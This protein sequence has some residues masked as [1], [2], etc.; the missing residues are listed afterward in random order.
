MTSPEKG[1]VGVG[2]EV[3]EVSSCFCSFL[4]L[5]QVQVFNAPRCRTLEEYGISPPILPFP[6]V[7]KVSLRP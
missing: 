3:S 4:R 2:K 1:R 7:D 5:L 6:S